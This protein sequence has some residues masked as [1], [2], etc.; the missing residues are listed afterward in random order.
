[1]DTR[2]LCVHRSQPM[3]GSFDSIFLYPHYYLRFMG[4]PFDQS[5]GPFPFGNLDVEQRNSCTPRTRGVLGRCSHLRQA[6]HYA[7][8]DKTLLAGS[9]I[10]RRDPAVWLS[11]YTS[12][13]S[14]ESASSGVS[15]PPQLSM[16]SPSYGDFS[17]ASHPRY[18]H[19]RDLGPSSPSKGLTFKKMVDSP[20]I[21]LI[22]D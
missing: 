18:L 10:H 17:T 12:D 14:N 7:T 1:M 21:A 5:K 20:C 6:P 3:P 15:A 2:P 11:A 16:N 4:L 22:D 13:P 8:S 19:Q 9:C